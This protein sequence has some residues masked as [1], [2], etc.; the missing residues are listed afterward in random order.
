MAME[1]DGNKEGREAET[2]RAGAKSNAPEPGMGVSSREPG[3]EA[4][5]REPEAGAARKPGAEAAPE[6]RGGERPLSRRRLLQ[7]IGTAGIAAAC[8]GGFGMAAP[9]TVNALTVGDSVYGTAVCGD[10]ALYMKDL[11]ALSYADGKLAGLAGYHAGSVIGG[12]LFVYEQSVSRSLHNGGSVIDPA[13][14]FPTDWSSKTQRQDWY[15]HSGSGSG[16]WVRCGRTLPFAADEFGAKPYEP[17]A[18]DTEAVQACIDAAD[19]DSTIRLGDGTYRFNVT[20]PGG[21]RGNGY[22]TVITP[23]VTSVPAITLGRRI[24]SGDWRWRFV[25]DFRYDGV[26]RGAAAIAYPDS[27]ASPTDGRFV[28]RYEF[29]RILF[30]NCLAAVRKPQGNIGNVFREL[31]VIQSD[32]GVWSSA[33]NTDPSMHEGNDHYIRCH[34]GPGIGKACYRYDMSTRSGSSLDLVFDGCLHEYVD[35]FGLLTTGGN[36]NGI[37]TGSIAFR[38]GWFE[39]VAGTGT[40]VIIDGTNRVPYEV[41]LTNVRNAAMSG[42]LLESIELVNSSLKLSDCQLSDI[43]GVTRLRVSADADSVLL[44]ERDN[45]QYGR[46][47]NMLVASLGA[48]HKTARGGAWTP[49]RVQ[50]AHADYGADAQ[51]Q[52]F[53]GTA[54][55]PSVSH[56]SVVSTQVA[57]GVLS[58]RCA[59]YAIPAAATVTLTA[60]FPLTPGHYIVAS[61]HVRTMSGDVKTAFKQAGGIALTNDFAAAPQARWR[62][63]STLAQVVAKGDNR[64]A[65][66]VSGATVASVVRM[67]D[68]QAVQFAR[69]DDALAYHNSLLC[70]ADS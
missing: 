43:T 54:S 27:A 13:A 52:S 45:S 62:C 66:T 29:A 56:P 50:A 32:Y 59:E 19:P 35:G 16:C 28:G 15:G 20:V 70:L 65:L 14:P 58:D 11:P 25:G 51:H 6:N 30:A 61:V 69:L 10:T 33:V 37:A 53:G 18:V 41:S 22:A 23:E 34:L 36:A 63:L 68:W 39:R 4:M 24:P 49:L 46:P 55:I 67:A 8:G 9:V 5:S 2:H 40:P 47:Q 31:T 17:A 7:S 48:P 12:G 64:I 42:L 44:S 26:N 3:T 57:D 21:L 60:P 1:Q 38:G